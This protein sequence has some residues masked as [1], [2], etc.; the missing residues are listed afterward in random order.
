V[1]G[2]IG[3]GIGSILR[4]FAIG[5]AAWLARSTIPVA[6]TRPALEL[7]HDCVSTELLSQ[8]AHPIVEQLPSIWT[9]RPSGELSEMNHARDKLFGNLFSA[10]T[11]GSRALPVRGTQNGLT[12][13]KTTLFEISTRNVQPNE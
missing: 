12:T 5:L 6:A 13:A 9:G 4:L 11:N 10:R 1:I 3:A 2:R 8:S 7:V